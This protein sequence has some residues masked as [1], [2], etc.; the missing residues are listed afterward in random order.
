MPTLTAVPTP[1]DQRHILR[2]FTPLAVSW[3]FMALE[4]PITAAFISRRPGEKEG[5][6]GMAVL[7]AL[8]IFIESPVIDL[9]ST[10]TTLSKNHASYLQLRKFTGLMMLWTAVVHAFVTLTPVY[11]LVT[12][13]L[14]DTPHEVAVVLRPAM[15]V[16]IPWAAFVGWRRFHH[17]ILIRFSNTRPVGL[18]TTVR[19]VAVFLIG[20][21]LYLWSNLPGLT[22]GAWALLG[23]V[24]IEA[25][26]IHFVAQE[27]IRENL[28]PMRGDPQDVGVTMKRLWAFHMPLT[29]STMAMV[30]SMPLVSWALSN[31]PQGKDAL[32]AWGVAMAV[33]F[34]FR[35]ITFALPETVIAL[36]RDEHSLDELRRFCTRVGIGC[37]LAILAIYFSGVAHMLFERALDTEPAVA[38]LASLAILVSLLVPVVNARASFVR[39]VLTAHHRTGP[40]L[41]AILAAV[42]SLTLALV[43]G[44]VF[45]INGLVVVGVATT[46]Q[47]AAELAVLTWFWARTNR[48]LASV[49]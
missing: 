42:G 30:A 15:V 49:P 38:S 46:L 43:L 24:A 39:G 4:G 47:V 5:L 35:A 17:G 13:R 44:V 31:S 28:D 27:T 2:F 16:M 6:A 33:V 8:C 3:V 22:L 32:A 11:W 37:A 9:L 12:E 1:I 40:R 48:D 29:L 34:M 45:K 14:L 26:F 20:G 23:S 19:V 36:Y 10:S 41:Y 18:G 21:G 25:L 7:M